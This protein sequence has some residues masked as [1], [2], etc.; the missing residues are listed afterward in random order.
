MLDNVQYY[1]EQQQNPD[2]KPEEGE[3]DDDVEEEEEDVSAN[4]PND[5]P[6]EKRSKAGQSVTL[7]D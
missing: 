3:D 6:E 2:A 7:H 1:I 5:I 4:R